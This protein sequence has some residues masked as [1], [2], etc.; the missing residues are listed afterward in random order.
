MPMEIE[1]YEQ[2]REALLAANANLHGLILREPERRL[3]RY[4]TELKTEYRRTCS[5]RTMYE[6]PVLTDAALRS[7]RLY[8]FCSRLPKGGICTSM[9]WR[10]SRSRS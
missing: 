3:D 1:E 8:R 7:S 4:L 2:Q 5:S 9:T 6:I 10:C